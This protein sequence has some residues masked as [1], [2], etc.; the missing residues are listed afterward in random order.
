M[1]TYQNISI[2]PNPSL[3]ENLC[4]KLIAHKIRVSVNKLSLMLLQLLENTNP[5]AIVTDGKR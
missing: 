1:N 4:V 5:N 3:S 2:E